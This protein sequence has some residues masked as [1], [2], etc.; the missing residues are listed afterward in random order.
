MRAARW[1]EGRQHDHAGRDLAGG[2]QP[3]ELRWLQILQHGIR[4]GR[5]AVQRRDLHAAGGGRR[6]GSRDI[7]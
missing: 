5:H 1:N 4:A 6:P 3:E 2:E 7:S